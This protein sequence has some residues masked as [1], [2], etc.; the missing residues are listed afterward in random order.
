MGLIRV[1]ADTLNGVLA[2]QWREY[3]YCDSLP[4][5]VLVRKGS[6]HQSKRSS[7]TKGS[8]NIISNGSVIAVQEGQCMIIVEQ[9]AIVEVSAEPGAFLFDSSTEP[10]LFYGGLGAGLMDSFK[11]FAKRFTFG[12]D[13]ANDQRVYFFNTK[14]IPGNRFGSSN[15][16]PF[17]AV[18][19]AISLDITIGLRCHGEYS[20]V[21]TDPILFY[22]NVS[23]NV[24]EEYTIDE[25]LSSQMKSEFVTALAPALGK[26]SD[27]GIRYHQITNHAQELAD[28][29]NQ[30]LSEKWKKIRGIEIRSVGIEATA[31]PEDAK[32]IQDMEKTAVFQNARMAGAGIASA[33]MDA[34]RDAAKNKAAGPMMAFAGMNMAQNAGGL[35]AKELFSMAA[36]EESEK[37][38]AGAAAAS[39]AGWSCDCGQS[40]NTGKF[41]SNCG[42]PR[43]EENGWS[44]ECGQSGN[45][46]KFCSNCGKPRP[47]E[48][49]S[50]KCTQC[51]WEA[52]DLDNPPKFCPNCGSPI[53]GEKQQ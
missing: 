11:L 43:P 18:N 12:G 30:I 37:A 34:M 1:A 27:M 2:D 41:C 28:A 9:G 50:I 5:G 42:K 21:L 39:S 32:M 44:C 53:G 22:K 52:K 35:N 31:T 3:F 16:I 46:G 17:R 14:E 23:G 6:K 10:T 15:P 47:L 38:G 4:N 26:L 49:S 45:T 33:Q 20:I 40:G 48:E 51:G 36:K 13:T 19:N 29:L 7:N 25:L 24:E 8:E